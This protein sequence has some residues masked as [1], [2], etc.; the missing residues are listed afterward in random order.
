MWLP[1]CRALPLPPVAVVHF[2]HD[3]L[4]GA[5]SGRPNLAEIEKE[6]F[7]VFLQFFLFAKKCRETKLREKRF[8]CNQW[9]PPLNSC[10]TKKFG[11]RH[12]SRSVW[13]L[14]GHLTGER[15]GGEKERKRD[16]ERGEREWEKK[17]FKNS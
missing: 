7:I 5:N 17:C 14:Q 10:R 16:R 12:F 2:F 15:G 4:R 3:V 8:L 6:P 1:P 9:P 11:L 13:F